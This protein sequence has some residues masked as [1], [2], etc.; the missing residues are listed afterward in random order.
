MRITVYTTTHCK[1][2]SSTRGAPLALS[3]CTYLARAKRHLEQPDDTSIASIGTAPTERR[4][5]TTRASE[6][7]P[8]GKGPGPAPP[9]GKFLRRKKTEF[10]P[11]ILTRVKS[12]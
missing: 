1:S 6:R 2:I 11:F 7:P 8:Q 9:F 5:R 10:Q 4:R 3:L 12:R